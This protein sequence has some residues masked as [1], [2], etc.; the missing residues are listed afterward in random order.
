[1]SFTFTSCDSWLDVNNNVDAP[2]YV[3][4]ELY[5]AGII[6]SLGQAQYWDTRATSVLT[7]GMGTYNSIYSNFANNFY[8][9][10]QDDAAETFRVVY[11]QHGMNLE[12]MINQSIEHEF[13]T[14]AGIG[15][16]IKAYG[17]DMLTKLHGDLPMKQAYEPG[18]LSHDYDYQDEI[19]TQIR[20]WANTAIEYLE[21]DDQSGRLASIKEVDLMYGG[22]KDKWIKF[23]HSVIVR[24]LSS[25]TNKN[26]FTSE[27]A[28]ELISHAALA[29]TSN[30]DN[31]TVY[32]LGGGNSAQYSYYNNSWGVCRGTG[33]DGYY[34]H[35][36]L[37]QVMTGTMP[38]Y[39]EDTGDK[40]KAAEDPVTK[41]VSKIYPFELAPKQYC[42]DTSKAP[43]HFDPRVTAKISTLDA[44]Y[45]Q[46]MDNIDSIKSWNYYGGG[47]TSYQG[48]I[49]YAP[50]LWGTRSGYNSNAS[51][52][53]TGRWSQQRHHCSL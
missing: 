18:R 36:F 23:A 47:F 53:G 7:Q 37:V 2:D 38:V 43:G 27:Y 10:S 19:Y 21:M 25:L 32:R 3:S 24:N 44:R 11:W 52:D 15:Y 5:L 48:P 13:W 41:E 50:N 33:T 39:N 40:V 9:K 42:A 51:Y 16:A 30:E 34:A 26:N 17:W 20:E 6:S 4:E 1:M 8:R 28:Q 31:A 29:F 12:N 35:D 45:Y 46:N 14:L 49:N 22:N